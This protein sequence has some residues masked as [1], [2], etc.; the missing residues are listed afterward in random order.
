MLNRVLYQ[1]IKD[2]KYLTT[3]EKE[4]FESWASF[5]F[6]I[7][8][9]IKTLAPLEN[10]SRQVGILLYAKATYLRRQILDRMIGGHPI[11][12]FLNERRYW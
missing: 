11:R 5:F 9:N 2:Q 12:I 3:D 8:A 7:A 6:D 10:K 4:L 1:T